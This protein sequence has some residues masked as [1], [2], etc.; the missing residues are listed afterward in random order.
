MRV[1]GTHGV[2]VKTDSD[3]QMRSFFAGVAGLPADLDGTDVTIFSF[4]GGDKMEIVGPDAGHP[5][6]QFARN[7]VVASLLA[8]DTGAAS[9]KLQ[10]AGIE[11]LGEREDGGHGYF[12]Q[13]FRA[14]DG[15]VFELVA[16]P[17]HP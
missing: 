8:E 4:P 14:P 5:P 17:A 13:H 9:R 1:N 3:D 7:A 16:D 11:L 12:W 6:G 15:T 2:G 10:A